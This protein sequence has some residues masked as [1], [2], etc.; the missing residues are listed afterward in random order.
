MTKAMAETGDILDFSGGDPNKRVVDKHSI[1]GIPAKGITPILVPIVSCFDELAVPNTSSRAI[2]TPAGTSDMLETI[3]PV[4]LT[5]EQILD[6][7]DKENGCLVWGGGLH[8]APADD[9]L[10]NVKRLLNMEA[11]ETFLISIIAKKVAMKV[12]HLLIDVPYGPETKVPN[13]SEVEKVERKF[14]ELCARFGIDVH[15]YKRKS[16]SPDGY[17]IGPM[18]EMRDVLRIFE[19]HPDRPRALESTA[20]D[21]AATLLEMSGVVETGK[22]NEI[23]RAKLENG[24]A[25]EKFWSIAKTQGARKEFKSDELVLA[26]FTHTINADRTGVIDQIE[27]RE[28]VDVARSLGAPFIK[29]AGMYFHKLAGQN[30]KSGEPLVTLYATSKERLELGQDVYNQLDNFIHIG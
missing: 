12:T 9:I 4:A 5:G 23:A 27:N 2:T 14:E 30:I 8:L 19:R 16:L 17:G 10:I 6:V 28:V 21:M 26:E 25:K 1:G 22:G 3:M 24:E 20:V 7:V 11:Y 13:I 29:E 18:L 15:V